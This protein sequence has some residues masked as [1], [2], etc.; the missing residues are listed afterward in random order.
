MLFSATN[1]SYHPTTGRKIDFF[2]CPFIVWHLK[3]LILKEK[4][5]INMIIRNIVLNSKK[6]EFSL[7][8]IEDCQF[9]KWMNSIGRDKSNP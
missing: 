3:I 9:M 7:L 6:L 5:E 4:K 1:E 8:K 2:I